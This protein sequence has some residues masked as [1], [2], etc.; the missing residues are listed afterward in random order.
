MFQVH[1]QGQGVAV[2]AHCARG[3]RG[4]NHTAA[5]ATVQFDSETSMEAQDLLSY[6]GHRP[7]RRPE[8][9]RC[10]QG[11]GR[12]RDAELVGKE[13]VHLCD[14]VVAEQR[15][16][17]ARGRCRVLVCGRT[18]RHQRRDDLVGCEQGAGPRD[19]GV[20]ARRRALATLVST[21]SN[22]ILAAMS[23]ERWSTTVLRP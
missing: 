20:L 3:A 7:L 21:S 16:C 18:V 2:H 1:C 14:G 15:G 19:G 5:A 17:D 13:A 12:L 10:L 6:G 9:A 4:Q 8:S 22:V 23:G 11:R